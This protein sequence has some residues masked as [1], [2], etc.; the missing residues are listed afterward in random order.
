MG[1][2]GY[3]DVSPTKELQESLGVGRALYRTGVT[4]SFQRFL[5]NVKFILKSLRLLDVII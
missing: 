1:V 4:C 3:H 2:Y 5:L